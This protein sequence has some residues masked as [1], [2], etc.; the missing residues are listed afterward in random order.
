MVFFY[1]FNNI[2]GNGALYL[3]A[4]DVQHY[5]VILIDFQ[6][7]ISNIKIKLGHKCNL[8]SSLTDNNFPV[9]NKL[10]NN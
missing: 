8:R 1:L 10:F 2:Q 6:E 4:M 5:C 3:F 7:R 9:T